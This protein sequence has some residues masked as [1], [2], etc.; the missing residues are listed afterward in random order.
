MEDTLQNFVSK[1]ISDYG[2][3]MKRNMEAKVT[4]ESMFVVRND[5]VAD[6]SLSKEEWLRAN[7]V[8]IAKRPPALFQLDIVCTDEPV[9]LNFAEVQEAADAIK[10]WKPPKDDPDAKCPIQPVA[11]VMGRVF[12][13]NADLE[14]TKMS[15]FKALDNVI[16]QLGTI[17]QVEK[18]LM[19]RLFWSTTPVIGSVLATDSQV[20]SLK[21]ELNSQIDACLAPVVEYLKFLNHPKDYRKSDYIKCLN[22][23]EDAIIN[24]ITPENLGDLD[25]KACK[26]VVDIH[27][28]AAKKYKAEIPGSAVRVGLFS[29]S[30]EIT[31]KT[32][33]TQSY[34]L[35]F[36][37][38][39][40]KF[41]KLKNYP[42]KPKI[43]KYSEG[44][45][46]EASNE[47]SS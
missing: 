33:Q 28:K 13:Y 24:A 45:C 15:I 19:D 9:C 1:S 43:Q 37:K 3:N 21:E 31:Q 35:S 11:S 25:L 34:P 18:Q 16:E 8:E 6:N 27:Q 38:Y 20:V 39:F 26:K 46:K 10:Q 32:P 29:I 47:K 41:Q 42:K 2:A 7:T 36:Q 22:M 17:P 44:S 4:T 14:R 23:D 30:P 5:F 12:K 40:Q